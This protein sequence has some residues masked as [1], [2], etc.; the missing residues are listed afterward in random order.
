LHAFK[1]LAL[2]LDEQFGVKWTAPSQPEPIAYRQA[3]E[4]VLRKAAEKAKKRVMV[5][6][7]GLDE[8]ARG[9]TKGRG[10][11]TG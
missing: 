2:Q 5:V 6:V 11:E 8:A 4:E 3:F 9:S 10:V 1:N 7:D